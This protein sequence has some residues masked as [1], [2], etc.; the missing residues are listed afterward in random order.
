MKRVMMI[1]ITS[2]LCFG[3]TA[4]EAAALNFSAIAGN[5]DYG[6]N[7]DEYDNETNM[8]WFVFGADRNI[9]GNATNSLGYIE[10]TYNLPFEIQKA[11][12]GSMTVRA[13]DIDPGD[14]M[15][16]YFNFESERVFAGEL[17]GSNGGTATTWET[18]VGAGS[19]SSLAGWSLTTYSFSAELLNALTGSTG[20][21]LQLDVQ[22]NAVDNWAAVID[23]AAIDLDYEPAAPNPIPEPATLLRA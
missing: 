3:F 16:V 22:N 15:D 4:F 17:K 14:Q 23:F 12:Y 11:N 19:T 6:A 9:T 10:W 21:L 1:I 13:W 20:F 7:R 8:D 2:V 5:Q 18:A